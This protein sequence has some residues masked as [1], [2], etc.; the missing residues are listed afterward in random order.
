MQQL[1]APT[2]SILQEMPGSV[3][4]E[5]LGAK[6]PVTKCTA[7]LECFTWNVTFWWN[8]LPE[9]QNI[10]ARSADTYFILAFWLDFFSKEALFQLSK[11][12][13]V[14]VESSFQIYQFWA[15]ISTWLQYSPYL[16]SVELNVVIL[17]TFS[18]EALFQLSKNV[19]VWVESCFQIYKFWACISTWLQ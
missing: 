1:F 5:M 3:W 2:V 17:L 4:S 16:F 6:C 15:C 11:N 12:V 7:K 8:S 14:W 13:M 19:M 10:E 18:K 9:I